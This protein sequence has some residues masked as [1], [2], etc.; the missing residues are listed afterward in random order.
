MMG[1]VSGI[2]KAVKSTAAVAT[3]FTIAKMG[4]DDDTADVAAGAT[5]K[6]VG[7]WQE[8]TANAGDVGRIMLNGISRLV[9]GG[10][11]TRGDSLTSDAAGKGVTITAS[12][13]KVQAIGIALASGVSGDIIPVLLESGLTEG[14]KVAR[15]QFTTVSASDTV[16]TGLATVVSAVAN[17]E[18]APILTCDRAN[19]N[20]GDQA[21]APVAGS[22]LIKTWMPTSVT[23]PTPIAATTFAQKVNWIAIGT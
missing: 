13:D 4:A 9:L 15:G 7:I 12:N 11:V 16:V 6:S 23:N 5:D 2:E 1:Q 22:I 20:I 19:A 8:T 3:A 14:Y 17:L 18:S 10:T 21:G